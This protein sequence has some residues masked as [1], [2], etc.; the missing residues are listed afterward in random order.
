MPPIKRF[1]KE[2]IV[3]TAYQI[4]KKEGFSGLNE[5]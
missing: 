5:N 2:D 3:N 4:V 1:E